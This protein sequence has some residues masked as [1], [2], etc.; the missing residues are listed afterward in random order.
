MATT[1]FTSNRDIRIPPLLASAD[2][3]RTQG[4]VAAAASGVC[5]GGVQGNGR[6]CAGL[7]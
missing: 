4:Q 1:K 6:N 3:M 7:G 2:L 5:S